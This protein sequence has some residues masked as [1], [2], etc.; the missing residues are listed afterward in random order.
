MKSP[1]TTSGCQKS[2][3]GCY[4]TEFLT[5]ASLG[6]KW[7]WGWSWSCSSTKHS[8]ACTWPGGSTQIGCTQ[9]G[10]SWKMSDRFSG[11]IVQA[12]SRRQISKREKFCYWNWWMQQ[13]VF[14]IFLFPAFSI[15]AVSP[16]AAHTVLGLVTVNVS[17]TG[18]K[19]CLH[20][21]IETCWPHLHLAL[22]RPLMARATAG[23]RI[24]PVTT[25]HSHHSPWKH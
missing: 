12:P 13:K 4:T 16:T 9:F 7:G 23:R 19:L 8:S 21:D 5:T 3:E 25:H 15:W 14:L 17:L 1:Q 22:Q 18:N 24:C 2:C 6:K 10:T 20:A 11:P